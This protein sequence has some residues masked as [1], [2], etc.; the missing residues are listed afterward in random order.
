MDQTGAALYIPWE[1]EIRND[2]GHGGGEAGTV[3]RTKGMVK[4]FLEGI[5]LV[6]ASVLID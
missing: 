4:T 1:Q 3:M 5:S 6:E 2:G